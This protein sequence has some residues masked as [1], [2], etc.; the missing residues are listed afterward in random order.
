MKK[1]TFILLALI[2]TGTAFGQTST[3]ASANAVII[4][5]LKIEKVTGADL[6]F[7]TIAPLSDATST[8]SVS[9]SGTPGGTAT[10]LDNTDHSAASFTITGD[11]AQNFTLTV[12]PPSTLTGPGNPIP[13]TVDSSMANGSNPLTDGSVTLNIGGDLDLGV[14]QA[15]GSYTGTINVSVAYE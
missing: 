11:S 10:D 5:A 14:N 4:T 13:F 15:A 9:N 6:N 2:T 1:I 3:T 12:T 8:F 7:G